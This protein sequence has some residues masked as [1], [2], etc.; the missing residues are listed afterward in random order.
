MWYAIS[1]RDNSFIVYAGT[2]EQ[3]AEKLDRILID[4]PGYASLN[5]S[6]GVFVI[7]ANSIRDAKIKGRGFHAEKAIFPELPRIRTAA[8]V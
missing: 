8:S 2:V 4:H 7:E 6:K 1:A 3:L 5:F